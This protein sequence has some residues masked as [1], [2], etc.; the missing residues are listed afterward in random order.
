MQDLFYIEDEYGETFSDKFVFVSCIEISENESDLPQKICNSCIDH[1]KIACDIKR[2]CI[3]TDQM[4]RSLKEEP[5]TEVLVKEED[6]QEYIYETLVED[7]II[8]FDEEYPKSGYLE[9]VHEESLNSRRSKRAKNLCQYDCAFCEKSFHLAMHKKEHMRQEHLDIVVCS[10][11]GKTRKSVFAVESCLNIHSTGLPHLCQLCARAFKW[12]RQ[13][14]EH[15]R[16]V[17]EQTEADLFKFV[18]DLC[19]AKLKYKPNMRRHMRSV[20]SKEESQRF[21][22][23]NASCHEMRYTTRASLNLHLYRCHGV[24]APE[25]CQSC[26]AGFNNKSEIRIH[27]KTCSGKVGKREQKQNLKVYYDVIDGMYQCRLCPKKYNSKQ[28]YAF[29]YQGYH[30]DNK[31]C[32]ICDKTFSDYPGYRRHVKA[33]H[34]KIKRFECDIAGCGKTFGKKCVLIS[35]R[36]THTGE[37]PFACNLCD[38]KTGDQPTLSKH[39]KKVHS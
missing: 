3:E 11:C 37:K 25:N 38:Y 15:F 12:R 6:E 19:G 29:H 16:M 2:K 20:H 23:P 34:L 9:V 28:N 1:L 5:L 26:N 18:C 33:V 30:R 4:L 14:D 31:T 32:R 7:E 13:L 21:V 35:H 17:H 36:N 39:R 22:C 24:A 8:D 27:L 10:G